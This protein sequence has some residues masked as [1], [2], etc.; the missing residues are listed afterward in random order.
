L[1]AI[2]SGWWEVLLAAVATALL[3]PLSLQ[4]VWARYARAT[5]LV[6]VLVGLLLG[7]GATGLGLVPAEALRSLPMAVL[8]AAIGLRVGQQVSLRPGERAEHVSRTVLG[9]A[10]G[11]GALVAAAVWSVLAAWLWPE[12][13]SQSVVLVAAGAA[14]VVVVGGAGDGLAV[15][16][17]CD[18]LQGRALSIARRAARTLDLLAVLGVGFVVCTFG[19]A[20]STLSWLSRGEW[21]FFVASASAL[22]GWLVS[23]ALGSA[24][25]AP[26]H[27][28]SDGSVAWLGVAVLLGGLAHA[29]GAP[30]LF[31]G[32]MAGL[33][34]G[35][36][37]A[38]EPAAVEDHHLTTSLPA[39]GA[40]L[41][42]GRASLRVVA[43]AVLLVGAAAAT[44]PWRMILLVPI[45]ALAQLAAHWATAWTLWRTQ[46][47]GDIALVRSMGPLLAPR[48]ALPVAIAASLVAGVPLGLVGEAL[49][50]LALVCVVLNELMAAAVLTGG[51]EDPG[52]G[53]ARARAARGR[54]GGKAAAGTAEVVA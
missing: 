9:T 12:A 11:V 47:A 49:L 34:A 24:E 32:A 15:A 37:S 27:P 40:D 46:P 31:A 20:S 13:P 44:W 18:R 50:T 52:A 43:L 4:R 6:P 23:P 3:L 26:D 25:D 8:L 7:I 17:C 39:H 38:P 30:A 1:T 21:F 28:V 54:A 48:G 10:L 22:L 33:V 41:E 36:A 5:S 45:V 53:G 29:A 35:R 2:L 19:A 51:S 16:A 42:A 14:A